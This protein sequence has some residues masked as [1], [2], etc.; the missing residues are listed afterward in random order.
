M[1]SVKFKK[2][3]RF[4][5]LLVLM[6]SF[7][8]VNQ[9]ALAATTLPPVD[10]FQLP[11]D[12]GL[13][14]VA[15]DGIDNGTKRPLSSSHNYT[16]GGAID[17]APHNNMTLG[18]N[19]SNFWVTAAAA[20]TV[21]GTSSCYIILDHGNGWVTQY[22]FL[23]NIQVKLGD[24]VSQNQRLAIIAD[25]VRQKFCPGSVDPDTPH[26]HFMLR[27]TIVG[28]TF[29]GWKVNYSSI[30]NSTTFTKDGITVGLFKPLLNAPVVQ[31]PTPTP[32]I[33][34]T[35]T[36][37]PGTASAT[38]IS[39]LPTS[40]STSPSSTT[41][42]ATFTATPPISG[43]SVSTVISQPNIGVGDTTLA[44]VNLNNV[45]TEG[46][47]SAEFTC[48]F[49][50]N[51]V[52]T[53]NIVITSLFG[54]DSVSIINVPQNGTF[55]VA[56]A[57][58]DSNKATTSGAAFTFDV[59]GLQAGQTTVDC[60]ARVSQGNNTLTTLPSSGSAL[61]ILA[62]T[63]TPTLPPPTATSVSTFTVTPM[64]TQ[65][66]I[67]GWL[68]FTDVTYSFQFQYPPQ[69]Q[70]QADSNDSNTRINNLPIVQPGTNLE[71][72]FMDVLVGQNVTECKSQQVQDPGVTV[73]INGIPFLKQTGSQGAA[74]TLFQLVEYSTLRD[75]ACVNLEFVLQSQDPNS[76]ATPRPAFD[77]ATESALF[78]QI[79]GTYMWLASA[80][81]AT[82]TFTSTPRE[83]PTPIF[84]STPFGSPT[85]TLSPT[86]L[87]TGMFNGQVI[88][89]E[90]VTVSVY[91]AN[92]V[93]VATIPANT[94][95]TFAITLEGGTYTVVATAS[96][97]LK[98][99]GSFTLTS[100]QN[101]TLPT[102]TLLAG[103]IDSNNVIDQFDAITIGM[104][105][106]A[107]VPAAADLNNDGI[108]NVLDLELLAHNY[109]QVGPLVWQ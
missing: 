54:P 6:T 72:K 40:T 83:S 52:Q 55:I 61:T 37:G 76:F 77:Y 79:I 29:A 65:T 90:S 26:L 101:S 69:G 30:F 2:L 1:I 19:T 105:Y 96:G 31:Q 88:A 89:S 66:P 67:P 45:P 97:F 33:P 58:S 16:V 50:A 94:N 51:L 81:T 48:T 34:P 13:A 21:V 11:W 8:P 74:G 4:L 39:T 42:T 22:Q 25:G 20:G 80:P 64:P 46:Y 3:I 85:S 87:P 18:E 60:V 75:G 104:N 108:I 27:P 99:Q 35:A 5:S 43:P 62:E 32:T 7:I 41:A 71:H 38:P 92:N 98:A 84:T 107:S 78:D 57:S 86:P 24:T 56:I 47:I 106:N 63:P 95:G 15:V 9:T 53:S 12:Q 73:T 23:A 82:P 59:K 10:M 93:Q 109:R 103:D 17:F 91:D 100:N 68:T 70:I 49:D 14:W 44:T 36:P 102:I 28:A